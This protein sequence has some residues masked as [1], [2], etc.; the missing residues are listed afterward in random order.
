MAKRKYQAIRVKDVEASQL[1]EA[2]S[3]GRCV[4]AIDVAKEDF[5]AAVMDG[6]DWFV[7]D[8]DK[9]TEVVDSK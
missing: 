9:F 2:L 6:A 1:V 4:V 3:G 5:F 7:T 8:F